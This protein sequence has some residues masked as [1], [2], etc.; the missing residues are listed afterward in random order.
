MIT[1]FRRMRLGVFLLVFLL[2]GCA[3]TTSPKNPDVPPPTPVVQ[4][5]VRETP[6]TFEGAKI[7]LALAWSHLNYRN[8]KVDYPGAYREMKTYISLAPK[9]ATDDIR[10][11]LAALEEMERLRKR[12]DDLGKRN[13]SLEGQVEKLQGNV[14]KLQ[15]TLDKAHEANRSLREEAAALKE[16]N[17]K[18]KETIEQLKNLDLQMEEKRRIFR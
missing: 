16:T 6:D 8:P 13:T 12:G 14:E 11:W 4:E 2:A 17:A 10:N 18:L 1:S 3:W 7:H 9:S 5:P 15:A